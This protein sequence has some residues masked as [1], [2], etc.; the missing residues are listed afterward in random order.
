ML[1]I[2][3]LL[4]AVVATW[5]ITLFIT[6]GSG[7]LANPSQVSTPLR[8]R[9]SSN[10]SS[11]TPIGSHKPFKASSKPNLQTRHIGKPSARHL[12]V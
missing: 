9:L 10:R 4:A 8:P 2:I 5:V 3:S 1:G 6:A 12:S 7:N 11:N